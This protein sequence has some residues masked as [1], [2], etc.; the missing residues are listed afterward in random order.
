MKKLLILIFD[1]QPLKDRGIPTTRHE[2]PNSKNLAKVQL[3]RMSPPVQRPSQLPVVSSYIYEAPDSKSE[4]PKG[5]FKSFF[6]IE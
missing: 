6:L 1:F 3:R 4:A 2:S 5:K